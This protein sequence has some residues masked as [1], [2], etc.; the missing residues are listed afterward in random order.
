MPEPALEGAGAA[1][2]TSASPRAC[3]ASAAGS[4]AAAGA[5]PAA[6]GCS[7]HRQRQGLRSHAPAPAQRLP[8]MSG[9]SQVKEGSQHPVKPLTFA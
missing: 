8:G 7:P 6:S 9:L 2:H 5:C 3:P 4:E 1:P